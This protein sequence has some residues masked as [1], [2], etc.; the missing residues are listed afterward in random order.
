MINGEPID[1]QMKLGE[2][3][4]AF[5]VEEVEEPLD[6]P[7]DMTTSPIPSASNLIDKIEEQKVGLPT[8]TFTHHPSPPLPHHT[9]RQF[10]TQK[11]I[12]CT[13]FI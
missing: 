9:H 4:E 10:P 8:S 12:F 3:G 11:Y 7:S 6:L 1:L 2:A 5:F 13:K